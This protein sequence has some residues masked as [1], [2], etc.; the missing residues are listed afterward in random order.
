[1]LNELESFF[2]LKPEPQQSCLYFLRS[3]INSFHPS[4][5]ETYKWKLPFYT[6][7]GKMFCYL[8]IDKKNDYPYVCFTKGADIDH[9]ALI[10]GERKKMKAFYINPYEDIDLVTLTDLLNKA[11]ALY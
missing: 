6:F 8:W 5:R 1:M 9:P 7:E 3:T 2:R 10:Q 11:I 4:I